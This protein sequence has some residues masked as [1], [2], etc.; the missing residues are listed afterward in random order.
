MSAES[1]HESGPPWCGFSDRFG[2]Y[3]RYDRVRTDAG[4]RRVHQEDICQ[5]MGLLP[6][7]KYQS[8]GDPGVR[9]IVELLT[10]FSTAPAEDTK[11]FVGAIAFNWLVAGTDAHAKN[12]A[13]LLGA[14]SRI[15]LAPYT[16]SRAR[17]HIPECVP[18]D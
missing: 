12:Y 13:L 10:T 18:L 17:C 5:A 2:L 7:Q 6:T 4:I 8:D 9:Q 3:E 14:E 1:R 11:T 16:I 15:R